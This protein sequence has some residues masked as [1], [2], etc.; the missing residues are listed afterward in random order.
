MKA[1]NDAPVGFGC[2]LYIYTL[3]CK[4]ESTVKKMKVSIG[5]EM[6]DIQWGFN[7]IFMVPFSH[8]FNLWK[9]QWTR[10]PFLEASGNYRTR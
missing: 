9:C 2:E 7:D 8:Y 6:I 5:F 10:G 3:R 1:D 4:V